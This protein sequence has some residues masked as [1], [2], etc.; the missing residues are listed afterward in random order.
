MR[1]PTR[2]SPIL[3]IGD[4]RS[5]ATNI[6]QHARDMG[7]QAPNMAAAMLRPHANIRHGRA[8]LPLA[9]AEGC[10]HPLPHPLGV[11]GT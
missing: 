8:C 10:G 4:P 3:V 9:K 2:I 11:R 5:V 7:Q 1:F 6:P